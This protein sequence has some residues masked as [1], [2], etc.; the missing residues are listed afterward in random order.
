MSLL[1]EVLLW[2]AAFVGCIIA[3]YLFAN[4]MTKG[5]VW[6]VTKVKLSGQARGRILVK[7]HTI[8][9]PYYRVGII[10]AGANGATFM[11]YTPRNNKTPSG[12]KIEKM[13]AVPKGAIQNNLG[14]DYLEVDEETNNILSMIDWKVVS[15]HDAEST[16]ALYKRIAML[17]KSMGNKEI[18][19]IILVGLTLL[20]CA[21]I[22]FKQGDLQKSVDS[23]Q[24]LYNATRTIPAEVGNLPA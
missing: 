8:S 13:F 2:I 9:R 19:I 5:L 11:K 12:Q 24:V 14:V 4:L 23:L 22:A 7:V 16:D 1:T 15:G 6:G 17:P 10:V 18:I 20:L 3:G 21:Y